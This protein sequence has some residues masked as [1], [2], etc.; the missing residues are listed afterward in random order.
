MTF[1]VPNNQPVSLTIYRNA[2]AEACRLPHDFIASKASRIERAFDMGEPVHMIVDELKLLYTLR[3]L[4]KPMKSPRAL[5]VR[6]MKIHDA[7][8]SALVRS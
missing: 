4:H 2:V 8:M 1:A 6:V 3:P 5:A 7:T